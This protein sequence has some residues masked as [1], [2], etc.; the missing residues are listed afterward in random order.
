MVVAS[1]ISQWKNQILTWLGNNMKVT[2]ILK[3]I[4]EAS[5]IMYSQLPGM[6]LSETMGSITKQLDFIKNDL[7][8]SK[9]D[10]LKANKED[11]QRIILGVQAI[12]EIEP[13][14]EELADLLCDID[15]EYKKL[16]GI[17]NMA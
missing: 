5:Q 3:K 8:R 4:E 16:H 7:E 10:L 1:N 12:R 11:V 9:P 17:S 15:Y 14:N 6:K 2:A 13:Q